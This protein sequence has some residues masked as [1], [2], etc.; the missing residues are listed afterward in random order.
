MKRTVGAIV[1]TSEN[2]RESDRLIRIL[3]EDGQL[4]RVYAAGA[5]NPRNKLCAATEAFVLSKMEL[6]SSS[7]GFTLDDAEVV[8]QFFELRM[9]L[10]NYCLAGYIGQLILTVFS[11]EVD[12]SLYALFGNML[13]LLA[14]KKRDIR[15]LKAVMEFRIAALA[16]WKP[17]LERCTCCGSKE[18]KTFSVSDGCGYCEK[19]S[20]SR[21]SAV[22]ISTPILRAIA[23]SIEGDTKGLFSFKLTGEAAEGFSRLAEYYI[24]YYIDAKLPA[25]DYYNSLLGFE[26]SIND[27]QHTKTESNS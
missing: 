21:S 20:I 15:L 18:I 8:E 6:F 24:R 10:K 11:C 14:C 25:L 9:S 17:E 22:A 2:R 5:R 19:C 3:C 26:E 27:I 16:G 23:V 7:G 1:L 4:V 12:P 13:F